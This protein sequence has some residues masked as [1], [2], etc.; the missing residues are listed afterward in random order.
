[1]VSLVS[2]YKVGF[3]HDIKNFISIKTD[4]PLSERQKNKLFTSSV[5]WGSCGILGEEDNLR[6]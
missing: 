6:G 2:S 4:F 5:D 3:Y 1:M